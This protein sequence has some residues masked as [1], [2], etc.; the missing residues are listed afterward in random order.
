MMYLIKNANLIGMKDQNYVKT[1]ILTEGQKIKAIG[2]LN[3]DKYPGCVVIDAKG[4]YV[5]PGIV[6]AHCHVGI[7]EEA[8]GFEGLD[9]NEMTN[10]VLPE[11]RAID[12]IKPQD[13]AFK[14]ALEAG[15]T[16]VS[17]GPG[18][19]NVIGGTFCILKTYG[20]TLDDMLVKEESAM[21]MAL[22]ENPKRVYKSKNQAPETRMGSAALIREALIKAREYL[23]K[24]QKYEEDIRAGKE[25]SK[26]DFNMK[27]ESLS[28]VFK[29]LPVKIHAHQQDDIATAMRIIG[30]FGLDG[31][32]EHA[33][34]GYLIPEFLHEHGQRVIIG[35]TLGSKSKYELRNKSFKAAKVLF[36]NQI[37]FAIMTDHPVINLANALTQV[38]LFVREGLPE[39]EGFRAVTINA[40]ELI[41]ISDRVGSI[42]IGK[43]ADI[44]I[45]N[46]HPLHYLAKPE[47]V[48][49]NGEIVVENK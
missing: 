45:W 17:T 15:I 42:E 26:P 16:T 47:Y 8:I 24:K 10:P 39:L 2:K 32:I 48:F 29:G 44:V 1:D 20:K 9:V 28:R 27:W 31:T 37:K 13:V 40:A 6:D 41:G 34:E 3:P 35:P 23:A 5:T 36:D 4:N 43:D 22:G 33:T 21:K 25:V 7:Y 18:S 11:L 49:V 14:D 38:G 46:N 30:E 12:G 19:A